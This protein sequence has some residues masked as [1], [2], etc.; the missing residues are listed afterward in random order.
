MSRLHLGGGAASRRLG[1]ATDEGTRD[2]GDGGRDA[3]GTGGEQS[4]WTPVSPGRRDGGGRRRAK[5]KPGLVAVGS[6]VQVKGL[7]AGLDEARNPNPNS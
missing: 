4:W 6:Q 5:P 2:A 7:A 1:A 3:G